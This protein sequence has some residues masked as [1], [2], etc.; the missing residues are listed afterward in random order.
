[1]GCRGWEWGKQKGFFL[2]FDGSF[3]RVMK[4]SFWE[5]WNALMVKKQN[6]LICLF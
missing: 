4:F 6:C 3:L 5:R 1:M 2:V